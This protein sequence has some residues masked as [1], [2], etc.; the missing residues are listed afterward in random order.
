MVLSTAG[1]VFISL[2]L[3]LRISLASDEEGYSMLASNGN[4][5]PLLASLGLPPR[6]Y[7]QTGGKHR[8]DLHLRLSACGDPPQTVLSLR[9]PAAHLFSLVWNICFSYAFC[10]KKFVVKGSPATLSNRESL[11]SV[12]AFISFES[13]RPPPDSRI[14]LCFYTNLVLYLSPLNS[15]WTGTIFLHSWILTFELLSLA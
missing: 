1:K 3:T 6:R 15:Q 7:L 12:I 9:W 4:T 2:D 11:R 14:S 13:E 8:K 10:K 5:K